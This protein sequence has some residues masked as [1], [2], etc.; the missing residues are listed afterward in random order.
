MNL[1]EEK[2]YTYGAYSS[3]DARRTAGT[4]RASADVRTPVTGDSLRE[5]FYELNRIR[6]EEVS[7]KEINDAKAYLTGVFPIRL[8]TLEGLIDQ[9]VQI[10]MFN[11]P[12][13]YLQVYRERVSA[14]TTAEIQR[15]ANLYIT[16]DRFAIVIVGDG[17]AIL[18]QIRPYS[19][20]IELYNTS[21]K[22]KELDSLADRQPGASAADAGQ[23]VG[24]WSLS[25]E[26]PFGQSVSAT[27][28]ISLDGDRVSGH[29][30]SP[31]GEAPLSGFT[32]Q[33]KDFNAVLSLDMQGELME[34]TVTGSVLENHVKG[35]IV[36][37]NA[38]PLS[39]TGERK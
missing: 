25:I 15:A 14:V 7:E 13:D 19:E 28:D 17:V 23:M 6:D 30:R 9:L 26:T 27:L 2:G 4:F 10:K 37:P 33:G 8:E 34:A 12:D 5:F 32:L 21:G 38:P 29:L 22:R 18:D 1:R 11:L 36:I 16:P 3:L 31:M 20:E 39:F 35:D 24:L